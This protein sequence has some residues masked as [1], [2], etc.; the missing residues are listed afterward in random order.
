MKSVVELIAK[1]LVDN[2]DNISVV[3]KEDEKGLLVELRVL[4]ADMGRVIGKQGR[5]AKAIRTIVKAAGLKEG[6]HVW[7]DIDVLS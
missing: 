6:Q 3:E 1:A 7:V 4:E 5:T 2:P